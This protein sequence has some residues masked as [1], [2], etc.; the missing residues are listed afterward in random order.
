MARRLRFPLLLLLA[1]ITLFA[2][3]SPTVSATGE[4][5]CDGWPNGSHRV[6]CHPISG[7]PNWSCNYG[8]QSC[9]IGH[10][11]TEWDCLENEDGQVVPTNVVGH[12]PTMCYCFNPG[13]IRCC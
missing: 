13:G 9:T 5:N 3:L 7:S 12:S 10:Q 11:C 1:S 8:V 6:Y 4:V 2:T